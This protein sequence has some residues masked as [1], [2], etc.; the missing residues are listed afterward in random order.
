[1]V[2]PG[3]RVIVFG[4]SAPRVTVGQVVE[5]DERTASVR[6]FD[7]HLKL[8]PTAESFRLSDLRQLSEYPRKDLSPGTLFAKDEIVLQCIGSIF[9]L[10][11]VLHDVKTDDALATLRLYVGERG[12]I[13]GVVTPTPVDSIMRPADF[14]SE[15]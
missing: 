13:T 9:Q 12:N 4:E 5:G 8:S 2:S 15:V 11:E 14:L 1:M 3:D 7:R 10:A 6:L